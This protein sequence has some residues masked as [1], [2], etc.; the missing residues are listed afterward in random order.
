MSTLLV[1]HAKLLL[2]MNDGGA[3]FENAGLYAENGVIK[4]VGPSTELPTTAD[5][6]LDLRNH[7]VMPGM[8]NTHHHLFQNLTRVV[9][10][11]QDAPAAP[12]EDATDDLPF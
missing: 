5:K 3:R 8:V 1:K 6:V 9:P 12:A 2:T 4:Q 7:I 11:A 10:A